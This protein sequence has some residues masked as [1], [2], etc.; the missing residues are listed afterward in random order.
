MYSDENQTSAALV[1]LLKSSPSVK[2]AFCEL[3]L[4][5]KLSA[6]ATR[7][8]E[9]TNQY[10]I[11]LRKH[12]DI[13]ISD[14]KRLAIIVECK[15]RDSIKPYQLEDYY[16]YWREKHGYD[17]EVVALVQRPQDVRGRGMLR[18]K[19][20]TWNDLY[21]HLLRSE[22]CREAAAFCRELKLSG[23]VLDSAP[24]LRTKRCAGYKQD[25]AAKILLGIR[26]AI[27]GL[28]GSV[29]EMNELP[30]FLKGGRA[31]W[32]EK[33]KPERLRIYLQPFGRLS[34][35]RAP[36][37][38]RVHLILH[39]RAEFEN[40][41]D[42]L[43]LL[44]RWINICHEAGLRFMRNRPGKWRGN[45]LLPYPFALPPETGLKRIVAYANNP[46]E[47]ITGF[48]WRDDGAAIRAGAKE[49]EKFLRV[50]DRF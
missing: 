16:Q 11:H 15:I 4:A 19:T 17:P 8:L 7:R 39:R 10:P 44:P 32:S 5:R 48:D 31:S 12:I 23:V 46:D 33:F 26:D 18:A 6:E 47:I 35:T 38:F 1:D 14:A 29:E 42:I 25:H 2:L 30:P 22:A 21:Q 9:V 45:E 27:P 41:E 28:I 49:L 50:A 3:V 36:F 20:V 24:S 13:L 43:P 37:G 34:N 40:Y